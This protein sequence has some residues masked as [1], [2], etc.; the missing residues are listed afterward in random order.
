MSTAATHV[1]DFVRAS[2]SGSRS[3]LRVLGVGLALGAA[4]DVALRGM[5]WGL[6][7]TAMTAALLASLFWLQHDLGTAA[8]AGRLGFAL[9]AAFFGAGLAWRDAPALKLLDVLGLVV[10]LGLL[11]SERDTATGPSSL[12]RYALRVGGSIGHAVV[13]PPL[14]ATVDADWTQARGRSLPAFLPSVARGVLLAL[15]FLVVFTALLA[16]ADAV[17]ALRVA[18]LTNVDLFA[19]V[20]H[21]V[22]IAVWSWVASGIL[23][24]GVLRVRPAH[25]FPARPAWLTPGQVEINTVVACLDLL[26]AAFVW[27]Q[28]RYLF[29]GA[30][31][32]QRIAGLTYAEYA[33]SGFFEL[34]AVAGLVLGLLLA[35]HWIGGPEPASR[36]GAFKGL[37]AVQVLLVFVMLASAMERMRLYRAEYGLTELRVYTTAFMAWIGALL[38]G[39]LLT[40]L[41]GRRDQ[42]A[43][44][45]LLSAFVTV[46]A[47]HALD[48]EDLIVRTNARL[49][50]PFDVDYALGLSHDAVPALVAL[51]PALAEPQRTDLAAGLQK[52]RARARP[53]W[54]TWSRGRARS[55]EALE[56]WTRR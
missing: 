10:S 5:P 49:G 34:V 4:A 51:Y 17:F 13:A 23:R 27:V 24:A 7:A 22:G 53:E 32:V 2:A 41:R 19:L 16:S 18:E 47:L 25:A 14:L 9:A 39:F 48:P 56:A 46:V 52:K 54:R 11:A 6:G 3:G 21:L 26:F 15:P 1:E 43:R 55:L 8:G 12:A 33:R 28:F 37:A 36:R 38:L 20:S 29:G 42:F 30:E 31:R 45:A 35:A 40:V 44:G 50:R